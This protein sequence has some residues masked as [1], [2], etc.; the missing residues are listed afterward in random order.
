VR[1]TICKVDSELGIV[2][3]W[4]NISTEG[5][6]PYVDLQGDH[7]PEHAMLKAAADFMFR[8]RTALEMHRGNS[9]GTVIFAW[10]M[11]SEIAKA[12]GIITHTT[13]LMIGMKVSPSVLAKFKSGQYRGFSIGGSI[14]AIE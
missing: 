10:P 13:G 14:A 1:A 8:S 6:M 3:G 9:I 4:A 5:G 11:T 7:I 12:F 2:F